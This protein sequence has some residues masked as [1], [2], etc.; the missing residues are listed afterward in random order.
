MDATKAAMGEGVD[1]AGFLR[2]A[3][4]AAVGGAALVLTSGLQPSLAAEA[5][6]EQRVPTET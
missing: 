1:R 3:A 4:A 2:T 5:V 6:G